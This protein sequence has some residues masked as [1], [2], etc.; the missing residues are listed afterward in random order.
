VLPFFSGGAAM[1]MAMPAVQPELMMASAQCRRGG[2]G[3]GWGGG[4]WIM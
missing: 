2:I 1:A 4:L 3:V